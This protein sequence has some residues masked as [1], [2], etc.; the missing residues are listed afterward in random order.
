METI[1]E[2][3]YSTSPI[4]L[5]ISNQKL[6]VNNVSLCYTFVLSYI[7]TMQITFHG[8][9]QTVTGSKHL[10]T[11]NNKNILLDCGL[12]QGGGAETHDW[13]MN[14]GFNPTDIDAVILSHAHIDHCGL[15]PKL[16]K[17][18]FSGKI[19]ATPA[20]VD[21]SGILL[22]DSAKIQEEDTKF[23]NKRR[24]AKGLK[25]IKPL[26]DIEAVS[27]MLPQFEAVPLHLSF[28]VV[29]GVRCTFTEAGHI[30]GSAVINLEAEERGKTRRICFSG[31]V[32]RYNDPILKSPETFPQS[33]IIIC[34]ST[35][36]DSLH[37]DI[38][39]SDTQLLKEIQYTCLEKKGRLIIPAF[40]VGR[41][42]EIVYAL[43]RLEIQKLLPDIK[44][45][46]DSPLSFHATEITKRH[47]ECY[48][49]E[50]LHYMQKDR[51][52]FSFDN[53]KFI[54]DVEDSK[55]L[56]SYKDPCVIISASGMAE[57]G[58]VKHHIANAIEDAR[59]TI[60]IVGYCE[61]QSLGARLQHDDPTVKIFGTFF[62]KHAEIHK[63]RSF[64]A[65]ADYGELCQ[66]LACQSPKLVEKMF[67]VHGEPE[68]Q[69]NFK[70]SLTKK[71]FDFVEIPKK[72]QS[73]H[74]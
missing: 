42:Q 36:G 39:F 68:V 35:Y 63:I 55:S 53:L 30:L 49:K 66:F 13:N 43:N 56:N 26:Y 44:F 58:R 40:S 16:V 46:V 8:A 73:Y 18:G 37:D 1:A 27:A 50:L 67:L 15:L 70:E 10:L 28:A 4:S 34:E 9:T 29:E 2:N 7:T 41:T 47:E 60:L 31:D 17:E 24:L 22:A 71:G 11:V 20:T 74:L 32:G 25:P 21:L 54:T 65:H 52:P 5:R 6:Y 48:N 59:N 12:F 38:A 33:D 64:S 45:F 57:A 23:I 3:N 51:E 19:F 69:N 62:T 14:F 72:H 61:P